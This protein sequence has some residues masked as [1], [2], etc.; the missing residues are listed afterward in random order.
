MKK[1]FLFLLLLQFTI[2]LPAQSTKLASKWVTNAT[3]SQPVLMA[4]MAMDTNSNIYVTGRF[5][6]HVKIGN[7]A[8]ANRS[9][10]GKG[11]V[12]IAKFDN[13]GQTVWV[14]TINTK[15]Y[16]YISSL[17]VND[18]GELLAAGFF[19]D[20]LQIGGTEMIAKKYIDAFIA[21][22]DNNGKITYIKKIEGDFNGEPL[23]FKPDGTGNSYFVAS[24]T[25]KLT[26][27]KTSFDANNGNGVIVIKLDNN[28]KIKKSFLLTGNGD[29]YAS[30]M[31]ISNGNLFLSGSF[32]KTLVCGTKTYYSKGGK[33]AFFVQFNENLQMKQTK[34][35]GGSYNDFGNAL[36]CDANGNIYYGGT[37]AG[38]MQLNKNTLLQS[39]GKLDIYVAKYDNNDSLIWAD[40]IGGAANEY[41]KSI[42]VNKNGKIYISGSFRG[43]IEKNDDIVVSQKFS[44]NVFIAKYNSLGKVKFI[45]TLGDTT[46]SLNQKLIV[47]GSGNL[48][49]SG[50]FNR[51]F[52]ALG[53]KSKKTGNLSFYLAKLYDCDE[54][55]HVSLPADTSVCGD[56]YTIAADTG[57]AEYYWNGYMKGDNTFKADSS[58]TYSLQVVDEHGCSSSDTM[59]LELNEPEQVD[60]GEDRIVQ[61]GETVLLDAGVGF[62]TYLWSN[63]THKQ[64]LL[65]STENLMPTKYI[66]SVTTTDKNSCKSM[67]RIAVT[68]VS[69]LNVHIFPNPAKNW[70]T[71]KINNIN[72]KEELEMQIISQYGQIIRKMMIDNSLETTIEKI[73]ISSL[74]RGEYYMKLINGKMEVYQKFIRL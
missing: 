11:N 15:S 27:G 50:N 30:D 58:G 16:C 61:Q 59:V 73:N 70:L 63:N 53:L 7:Y 21:G 1:L 38:K 13:S 12:F 41:L 18:N 2:R 54:S 72:V 25:G 23:F 17:F 31:V 69:K 10:G 24:F 68:I 45:E 60:L 74:N 42:V 37:F 55:L 29:L 46:T 43:K 34:I 49:L 36:A 64:K 8:V 39:N 40:N 22:L 65:V 5:A 19:K 56:T 35:F 47:N 4:A 67:D 28:N 71:V 51:Q 26:F 44:D 33:D 3:G 48:Y 66:Y 57:F 20:T 32:S 52:S 14:N 62:E 6:K 9:N